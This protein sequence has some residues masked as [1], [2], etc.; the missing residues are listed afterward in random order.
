MIKV[1]MCDCYQ[2][3]EKVKRLKYSKTPITVKTSKCMGT[4]NCL[5]CKCGGDE[6]KCDFYSK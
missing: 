1:N 6:S 5:E 2:E 3:D 4:K